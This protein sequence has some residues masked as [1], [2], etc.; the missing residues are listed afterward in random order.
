[1]L[2]KCAKVILLWTAFFAVL[3]LCYGMVGTPSNVMAYIFCSAMSVAT[4]VPAMYETILLVGYMMLKNI[5]SDAQMNEWD[6][7]QLNVPAFDYAANMDDGPLWDVTIG[8][9]DGMFFHLYQDEDGDGDFGELF[10]GELCEGGLQGTHIFD[11]V[12]FAT[13]R[14][15]VDWFLQKAAELEST[16]PIS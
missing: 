10:V 14:L 1:M 8:A 4:F 9:R 2:G 15:C 6:D 12:H 11:R 16:N 13:K 7:V 5:P 3:W